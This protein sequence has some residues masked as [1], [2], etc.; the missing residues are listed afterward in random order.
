MILRRQKREARKTD[1]LRCPGHLAF[2]R[3]FQCLVPDC[4]RLP[5]EAAHW[6]LGSHSGVAQKPDDD[7]AVPLCGGTD[8]HHRE[9]HTI[10]EASFCRKYHLDVE[11]VIDQLKRESPALRRYHAKQRKDAA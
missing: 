8:G 11:L 7:R 6:R 5:V 2:V 9:A 3:T 4:A 10:G 1:R